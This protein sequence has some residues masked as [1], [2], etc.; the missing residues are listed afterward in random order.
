MKIIT[1]YAALFF[2]AHNSGTEFEVAPSV[3]ERIHPRAFDKTLRENVCVAAFNHDLNIIL[4]KNSTRA[5]T[6]KL[7]VDKIGL[8]YEI[9]PPDSPNGAN[10]LEA[11]KRGDVSGSSF[12]FVPTRQSFTEERRSGKTVLIRTIEELILYECGP[13]VSPAYA[14]ASAEVTS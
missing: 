5:N 4:G 2:D 12:A 1:G 11:V 13:V 14:A 6:L 8:R 9:T 3:F 7:S 10:V